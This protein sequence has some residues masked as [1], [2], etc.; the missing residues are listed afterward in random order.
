MVG[1]QPQ[2]TDYLT[3]ANL[4]PAL[5]FGDFP[6]G[7][8][9]ARRILQTVTPGATNAASVISLF[10]NEW[11]A[12]NTNTLADPSEFPNL[13]FDDWFE[14]YNPGPDPVDLGGYWLTDNLSNP[15]G[16]MVPSNSVY[17]IPP[18]GFLLVWADE[19]SS[20]NSSNLVD[21]H[22]NFRLGA[23]REDIGLFAPDLTLVDSVNFT[24][25]MSDISQGRFADGA[26]AIYSMTTPTPR[27]PNTLGGGNTPPQLAAIPDKT[28]TLGQ[29]LSFTISATDPEAPPQTLSFN[30]EGNIPS[31]AM[32]GPATGLFTWTPTAQQTPSTN[33][34][35][36]RV[37]DSG[38]PPLSAARSFT[39]FVVGPPRISG[40]TPPNNSMVTLTLPAIPGKTYRVEYKNTLSAAEWTPLGGD[41]LATSATLIIED[42]IGAQPQRFYRVLLLD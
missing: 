29:T 16:F 35:T 14:I 17:V 38:V 4:G 11:M 34:L 6:D 33:A 5:S 41:R 40:I 39:V 13:A 7:Q 22:V 31:G 28:V 32:A 30:L 2:I 23:S 1:A 21:L 15:R 36:V 37:T 3:Y 42:N 25:Q 8:P 12:S 26:S 20:I 19:D 10:I 9:F 24:N 18:G 27:L